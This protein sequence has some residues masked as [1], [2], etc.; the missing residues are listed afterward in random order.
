MIEYS[1]PAACATNRAAAHAR[2]DTLTKPKGSL[3]V[4][5]ALAA[6]LCAAQATLAP[7]ADRAAI[8][9]FA[10]DHGIAAEGVSAYPQA[11]TAQMVANFLAG[12][13]AINVLARELDCEL[14]IVDVGVDA[15]LAP[16]PALVRAKVA[17]GTNNIVHSAAMSAQQCSAAVA[18]GAAAARA[19]L[20]AG[21]RVVVLGEMGIGNTAV[22]A[23]LMHRLTGIPLVDCVGH[24]TGV[25]A[26]GLRRKIEALSRANARAPTAANA[27]S[28][29]EELGGLEFAAMM[30]A[31]LATAEQRSI[32]LV[33]GFSA[34]VAVALG[35]RVAPHLLDYCVFGH[36]SAE[37]AHRRLLEHLGARPLLDLGLRLGEASGAALA[38]PLLRASAALLRQMATFATAGVS[39]RSEPP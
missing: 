5:E 19:A 3:G 27:R 24:G 25:D 23:L 17:R 14:R 4:L 18:A 21:A 8:L 15:E 22:A 28:L 12:G 34:T 9:V 29:L 13:A 7:D 2:L 1:I 6:Q 39:T 37:R 10:A 38:L 31:A 30:G 11:V 20:V 36:V 16:Q 35:A 26:D 33:D 32:V